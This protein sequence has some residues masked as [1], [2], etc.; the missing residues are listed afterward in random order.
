[1]ALGASQSGVLWLVLKDGALIAILGALA[2]VPIAVVIASRLREMLYAVTPFDPL[3]LAAVLATLIVVVCTASVVPA[4]RAALID[5][6]TTMK[7]D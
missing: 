5:P 6:A 7:T 2:G 3:I 1:M 4:R